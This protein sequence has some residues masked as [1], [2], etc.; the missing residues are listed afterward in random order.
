NPLDVPEQRTPGSAD[1]HQT[2]QTAD[3]GFHQTARHRYVLQSQVMTN[4]VSRVIFLFSVEICRRGGTA[5]SAAELIRRTA[6]QW[7]PR[8]EPAFDA[9]PGPPSVRS[10]CR[11]QSPTTGSSSDPAPAPLVPEE[12]PS[13]PACTCPFPGRS[14]SR[15]AGDWA[16]RS[17]RKSTRLNSSHVQN[18]YAV[19]C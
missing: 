11:S 17:D 16:S 13:A 9:T 8:P 7:H 14:A 3:G 1:Q 10:P 12:H 19:F 18:S 4:G 6:P 5:T 2:G 15:P